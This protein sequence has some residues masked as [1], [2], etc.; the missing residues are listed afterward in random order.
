M[1]SR[2]GDQTEEQIWLGDQESLLLE[3]AEA[4]DRAMIPVFLWNEEAFLSCWERGE[5]CAPETSTPRSRVDRLLN[6]WEDILTSSEWRAAVESAPKALVSSVRELETASFEAIAALRKEDPV[7][8][9]TL[10]DIE[11]SVIDAHGRLALAGTSGAAHRE[12]AGVATAT[13]IQRQWLKK[14]VPFT[15]ASMSEVSAAMDVLSAWQVKA[16]AVCPADDHLCGWEL[17]ERR[18]AERA[19]AAWLDFMRR[20]EWEPLLADAPREL[21]GPFLQYQRAAVA[22][23]EEYLRAYRDGNSEEEDLLWADL[24]SAVE[25]LS[26]LG[27]LLASPGGTLETE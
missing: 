6:A 14:F 17:D 20:P 7:D 22:F 1:L 9:L 16:R 10:I 23:A 18:D 24:E 8:M 19:M 13:T 3:L 11:G 25:S 15:R 2:R 26:S 27:N 21:R 5:Y 12:A 4:R